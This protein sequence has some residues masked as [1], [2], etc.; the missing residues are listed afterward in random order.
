MMQKNDI[1]AH[2]CY[3]SLKDMIDEEDECCFLNDKNI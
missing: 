1:T 2:K 3:D